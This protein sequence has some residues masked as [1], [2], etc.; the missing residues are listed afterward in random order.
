MKN[1]ME[2]V[3]NDNAME[4]TEFAGWNFDEHVNQDE[5]IDYDQR[6]GTEPENFVDVLE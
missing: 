6:V 4:T 1:I 3:K 2:Y 5:D